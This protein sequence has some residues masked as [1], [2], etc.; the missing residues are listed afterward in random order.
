MPMSIGTVITKLGRRNTKRTS[1]VQTNLKVTT[2]DVVMQ[3]S[4]TLVKQNNFMSIGA[5][6]FTFG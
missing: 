1:S 3:K 2:D 6:S 5:M 4:M